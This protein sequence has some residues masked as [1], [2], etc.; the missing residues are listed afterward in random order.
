MVFHLI[1]T[2]LTHCSVHMLKI[3]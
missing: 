1:I 3:L 2:P